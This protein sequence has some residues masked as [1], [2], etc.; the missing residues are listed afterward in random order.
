GEDNTL[1]VADG[2]PPGRRIHLGPFI[3]Q[4]IVDRA[5]IAP[6]RAAAS[7][8]AVVF[9]AFHD[10]PPIRQHRR[11]EIEW[12]IAA[13]ERRYLC[14]SAVHITAAAV[15]RQLVPRTE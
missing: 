4:R 7:R 3:F 5:S 10:H 1:R 14:P 11:A 2:R 13:G 15:R 12:S 6:Y 8:G 9:A